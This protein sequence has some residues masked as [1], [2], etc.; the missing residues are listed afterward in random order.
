MDYIYEECEMP[1]K[2][3]TNRSLANS[4]DVDKLE[5]IKEVEELDAIMD[6]ELMSIP[7]GLKFA[8]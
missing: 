1:I 5:G 6:E 8:R 2:L 7:P 3:R 4:N